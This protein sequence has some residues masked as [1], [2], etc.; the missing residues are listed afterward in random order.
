MKR[1]GLAIWDYGDLPDQ[2]CK[3]DGGFMNGSNGHGRELFGVS[4]VMLGD[5]LFVVAAL[6]RTWGRSC[7]LELLPRLLA[8]SSE[9]HGSAS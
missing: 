5:L 6:L 8:R 2:C 4:V 7:F 1:V 3:P 9:C